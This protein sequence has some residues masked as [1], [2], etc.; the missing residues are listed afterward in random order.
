MNLSTAARMLSAYIDADIPAF[1]WGAPGI[2][3]SDIVRATAAARGV[4]LIDVRAVLLDPVD[5]RGLPHIDAEGRA[6]WSVPVF[7][8]D[9]KRDGAAGIL[10][11]DELNA[12]APS[13]QAACFQLILDR[14]LGEYTLPPGWRIV[15][16]GNRQ[17]DRAAAQRMPTAL[18][19]RFAH[20]DA[21]AS[22]QDWTAW[23][24]ANGIDPLVIAFVRFRPA[25][26]HVMPG[27]TVDGFTFPADARAFPT[28]RAWASVDRVASAP[29]ADRMALVSGIVGESP[30]AEFDGFARIFQEL[31]SIGTI[32]ANPG[33]APVPNALG[34]LYALSAALSRKA[35]VKNFAAV[36]E[37]SAR[38]PREFAILTVV[39]AVKREKA[40]CETAAFVAW[41]QANQDVTL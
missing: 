35:D 19:N 5:L 27:A 20:I 7:L 13:V 21:E 9:A 31:P 41:A 33:G 23:A 37:Y 26:L 39:D 3:K 16:A 18:A 36:V 25:L 8:P 34:V 38:M 22:V 12:A 15:A 10:F 11:L 14:R 24:N 17:S 4:P 30:A 1:V 6:A 2:G 28:P 32:L 40:L 29:A